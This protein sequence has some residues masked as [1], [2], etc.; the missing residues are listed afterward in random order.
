MGLGLDR[1]ELALSWS[2]S[3]EL[4]LVKGFALTL[5]L[6][7]G[8]ELALGLVLAWLELGSESALGPV[9]LVLS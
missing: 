6:A 3:R 7:L 4:G 2:T 1:V 9:G 5:A 8:L